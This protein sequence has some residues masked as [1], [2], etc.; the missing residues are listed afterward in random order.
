MPPRARPRT[1]DALVGAT[2]TVPGSVFGEPAG[3]SHPAVVL[4]RTPRRAAAY[5][6]RFDDGSE[7]WFPAADVAAWAAGGK[8]AAPSPTRTRRAATTAKAAPS[9]I[10]DSLST[11]AVALVALAGA[12]VLAAAAVTVARR[13]GG[14]DKWRLPW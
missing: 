2:V 11:A 6:V 5:D 9:L 1:D 12:I 13:A 8:T 10:D 7:Y 14:D 4:R 3:I